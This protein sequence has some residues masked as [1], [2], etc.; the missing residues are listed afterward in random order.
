LFTRTSRAKRRI[1]AA[2][3]AALVGSLLAF[4]SPASSLDVTAATTERLS[5]A[6]R[7]ATAADIATDARWGTAADQE[8]TVVNGENFP[9]GLAAAALN[10]RVL[11]VKADSIPAETSAAITAIEAAGTGK[12]GVGKITVVGGT[13]VVSSAVLEQLDVLNGAGDAAVRIAGADRYATALAVAKTVIAT[14]TTHNVVLATGENFPDALAAGPFAIENSASI[15]LNSGSA[16]RADVKAYLSTLT[17]GKVWI[18]GGTA[19]V[20]A[21]VEA[22]IQAMGKNVQ[23]ISGADREATAAAVATAMPLHDHSVVLVN[24]NGFADALA[25]APFAALDSVEGAILLTNTD[26]IPAATSGYHGA[27][28]LTLGGNTT[29]VGTPAGKIYAMGGI[30]VVSDAVLAGAAAASKCSAVTY[31][32][33]VANSAISQRVLTLAQDN[34]ANIA[35]SMTLTAVAGSAADGAAG[36]AWAITINDVADGT[37]TN[38]TVGGTLA[39][40]T[41][42]FNIAIPTLGM[43]QADFAAAWNGLGATSALFTASA[44]TTVISPPAVLHDTSAG[45]NPF[46]PATLAGSAGKQTQTV[47]LTFSEDVDDLA[48]TVA[49]AADFHFDADGA[50]A[51]VVVATPTV[52]APLAG[53]TGGEDVYT[54]TF[55]GQED[56]SKVLVAGVSGVMANVNIT[57]TG[58]GAAS[59]V[60]SVATNLSPADTLVIMTAG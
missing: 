27:K 3:L 29:A 5:G 14:P 35:N 2:V 9:D 39:A 46:T 47:V 13:G 50:G 28:C 41:L 30:G 49:V 10:K 8:I 51:G 21:S 56:A 22:E 11:L 7:Y 38:A 55:V 34:G 12:D 32:A 57:G 36:N 15:V 23:R 19:A 45:N 52:Q 44:N 59:T 25:A 31:T 37:A 33:T 54:F 40:P 26:S 6:N 4:A 24:R 42:T 58:P 16:L 53:T 60:G 18:I 20:P 17:T 1:G 48:G 43:S